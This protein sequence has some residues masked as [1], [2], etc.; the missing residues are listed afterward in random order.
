MPEHPVLSAAERAVTDVLE[1]T[2]D[3]FVA[4]DRQW[5]VTYVNGPAPVGAKLTLGL[6]GAGLD[7]LVIVAIVSISSES[8][9]FGN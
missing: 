7:V 3:G 1:R 5:R 9:M 6:L 8:L 2:T 4:Y